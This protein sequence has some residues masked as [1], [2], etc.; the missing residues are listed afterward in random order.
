MPPPTAL[1]L[2]VAYYVAERLLRLRE[3]I[4]EC[5]VRDDVRLQRQYAFRIGGCHFVLEVGDE[6]L[7]Y[8]AD[9]YIGSLE[10]EA[11]CYGSAK[12][13]TFE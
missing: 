12:A 7:V 2:G 3:Q 6:L 11:L 8:V 13:T 9:A 5:L 4:V 1:P 10:Q